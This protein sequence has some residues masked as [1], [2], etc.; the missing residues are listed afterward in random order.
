MT[1]TTEIQ[2]PAPTTH[3]GILAWVTEVAEL[4][5]PDRIHWCTGSDEEWE[6]LTDRVAFWVDQPN[7]YVTYHKSY[8]ES[9][10]WALSELFKKGLLYQGHK[11]V[12]W[13]AQG[14]TRVSRAPRS[15]CGRP[16]PGRFRP[17]CT[18]R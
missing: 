11:V 3:E 2:T 8:V 5:R 13:W 4:T 17:T 6:E 16:P 10:W 9:V 12:W 14:G 7:A 18:P 1:T 15:R